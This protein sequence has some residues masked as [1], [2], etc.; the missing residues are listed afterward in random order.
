MLDPAPQIHPFAAADG[1]RQAVRVW[2]VENPLA[3]V[4]CLHG[5]VSHGGWYL[6]SCAHLAGAG[7]AVHMLDRR[8]SGLNRRHLGAVD[9]WETWPRDVE[10]YLESLP[11]ATPRLLLGIS[12]GGTLATAVARRRP[13]LLQGLGLICPGLYS[14]KAAT[15]WQRVALGIAGLLPLRSQQVTIPLAGSGPLY[16][17]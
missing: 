11:Q 10:H 7:F 5:I 13:E 12:W 9:R 16:R 6:T 4:V 1:Y 2:A 15:L 14:K 3:H 8:G 17:L